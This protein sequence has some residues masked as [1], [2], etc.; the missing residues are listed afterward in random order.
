MI[1]PFFDW[2][3]SFGKYKIEP[4]K[5]EV[6]Q[7][8]ENGINVIKRFEGFESKPYKD[9][10]GVPTIGY[11][12]TYYPNGKTVTMNDKPITEAEAT[13]MLRYMVKSY[14][15]GVDR[16]VQQ[17]INQNQ[18]DALTSFA[19]NLGLGALKGSTLLKKVNKNP[20]DPDIKNQFMRWVN[21]G[22]RVVKGLVVRRE[23]ES[24]LYFS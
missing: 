11:G 20:N 24:K 12:A 5:I 3:L 8:S 19:Y 9:V 7:I 22:G 13:E 23:Y 18:F 6:M 1:L 16:Y 14:A 17:P 4:I 2:I 15:N 21:A 10:A